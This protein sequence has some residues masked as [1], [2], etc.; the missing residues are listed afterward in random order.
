MLPAEFQKAHEV[1]LLPALWNTVTNVPVQVIDH[2]YVTNDLFGTA[3]LYRLI[4]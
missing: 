3:R 4:R 1:N 2:Y